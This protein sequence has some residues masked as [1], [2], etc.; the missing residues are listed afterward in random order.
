[1]YNTCV[2]EGTCYSPHELLEDVQPQEEEVY[3]QLVQLSDYDKSPG[4]QCKVE[5]NRVI[6]YCGMHS[7]ISIVHN[8][9][10]ARSILEYI[11]EIGEQACRRLHETGTL[12]IG[13]AILDLIKANSTNYRSTTAG[14]TTV[15]GKCSGAQFSDGYGSWDNVMVQAVVKITLRA[16]EL[17]VKRAAE[18]IIMP[19]G[20]Y[21][22]ISSK[23]CIDADGSETYWLPMPID[24]CHF[25]QY[26][27][28]YE[29]LATKLSPRVNHSIPTV[30]TVT[31]QET[32]FALTKTTELDVF[33][34]KLSQTEHPKLFI[35]QTQK[36]RTFKTRTRISVDNLDI[37]HYVNSKFI[38]VKRYIKTQLAQLYRNLMEQK[39]S[40]KRQVLQNALTLASIAPDETAYR[41]MKEPGYTAVLSREALHLV[42]CI[43]VECKLR[44]EE[45]CYTELPVTH[46]NASYFLQ[47]RSRILP[48]TGTLRDCN[49]LLPVMYKLH[50][51][52][53]RLK[54][55]PVEVLA[56]AVIQPLT[57][58]SW[59]YTS[60]SSL[61]ISDI[62]N[63]EDL[64]H[65]WSHIIFPVERPS[66]LNT[67]ARGVMGNEI[68]AGSI[69][70]LNLLDEDSL[71]S[72][73]ES[74]GKRVWT[75]ERF[76]H[77]WVRQCRCARHLHHHQNGEASD[78]YDHPRVRT[79]H[80]VWMEHASYRSDMELLLH[81]NS[82]S[83]ETAP[84]S[85]EEGPSSS[86][87]GPEVRRPRHA[88]PC[89]IVHEEN[90]VEKVPE[91]L[92]R[93]TYLELRQY[94]DNKDV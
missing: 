32:T 7:H 16:L 82:R 78:R 4:L 42:K 75:L 86:P 61:T 17:S 23:L 45:Q 1:S 79:P 90:E 52:W 46:R 24:N 19:S 12:T 73:A 87:S 67:I 71:E 94:L 51:T 91:N 92:K 18:Y 2:H 84:P 37:F 64:D 53:F 41:I 63:A 3:I 5:V 13:N 80:N 43:P 68:P 11:Q 22:K 66:M 40:L 60:S 77:I 10:R 47:P 33:D 59:H 57:H 31:T 49:E 27:I 85:L 36:G 76:R 34:Y 50:G 28:L 65:L 89:D 56:S 88:L 30:Y 14:S 48:K 8:G 25:D 72:I 21:C 20:T 62:Y 55:K 9:R 29:G 93:Y 39:C 74:A 69:S 44:H 54:P 26:D 35:L 38:Y 58:P 81:L 70:M 83:K 6:N 15:D